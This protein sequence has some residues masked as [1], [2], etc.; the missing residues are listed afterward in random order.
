MERVVVRDD[1][2]FRE[3]VPEIEILIVAGELLDG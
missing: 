1:R 3:A 2:L